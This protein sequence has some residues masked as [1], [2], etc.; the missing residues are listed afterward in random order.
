MDVLLRTAEK[1]GR[2][3]GAFSVGNMEMVMGAVRAAEEAC[4][5]II[6]QIAETR[7]AASPLRLMGPMMVSAAQ[8]AS[9][10][11]AVHLDHGLTL[12][13]VREALAYG[14]TSVMLDA[15]LL[16]FEE[17]IA[18]TRQVK[19][20]A[21][22]FGATVEAEL[23]VV[24]GNEGDTAEH[25]ILCTDPAL[26]ERFVAETGVDALAVAI[27]NAHGNY[28]VLP[29]LRFD[30]LEQISRRVSVPLVLHGGTG[31]T[32]DMFR[33]AILLGIRKINIATASFDA[34][35]KRAKAYADRTDSPDYFALSA[36][37]AAGVYENVKRH[38]A[39]FSGR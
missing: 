17:N 16:P 8:N 33:R 5:P 37:M 11:I 20:L 13:C 25:K 21:A 28:P 7:L 18:M 10:P 14:F 38:I 9:V 26:A 39:V 12:D 6:L 19:A 32:D 3:V 30:I 2:A 15:S 24:G 27:G 35:A 34:L 31:M 4:A 1:E 36:E 22:P 29:D 23:G